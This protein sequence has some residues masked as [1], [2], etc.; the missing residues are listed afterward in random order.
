[1]SAFEQLVLTLITCD[2]VF[3]INASIY[4]INTYV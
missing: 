4:Y 3:V 2:L 1:M